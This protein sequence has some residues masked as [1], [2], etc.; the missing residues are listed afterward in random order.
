ME[1]V[2]DAFEIQK[3]GK[4]PPG[5]IA[6]N[7]MLIFDVKMDFTWK[8]A[9]SMWRPDRYTFN[10]DVFK[11]GIALECSNSFCDRCVEWTGSCD[12]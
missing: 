9:G 8:V 11:C 4:P 2:R 6:V 12:G 10:L 5:Y 3:D 7:L 1:N